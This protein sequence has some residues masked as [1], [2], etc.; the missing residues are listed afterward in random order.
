MA[1]REK[2]DLHVDV[3][4]GVF[5][6]LRPDQF[7]GVAT[8]ERAKEA[9]SVVL[10]E[11]SFPSLNI[12]FAASGRMRQKDNDSA[13]IDSKL[14]QMEVRL[15]ISPINDQGA[16][17]AD[18]NQCVVLGIHPY[19]TKTEEQ[20]PQLQIT[21]DVS[22]LLTAIPGIPA[23][24]TGV[25]SALGLTFGPLFKPK[26]PIIENAFF[27]NRREFGWYLRS[28]KENR[29]EGIHY[30]LAFLQV[31]RKVSKL[32]VDVN[33]GSD[34]DGGGVDVQS[35]K[36]SITIE[37]KHP[38]IPDTPTI[39][40]FTNP[41]ELPLVI[42]RDDVKTLLSIDDADLDQL[43][44]SSNGLVAFGKDRKHITKGSLI[45]VLELKTERNG[46]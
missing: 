11:F 30:G 1:G 17:I 15:I 8:A 19:E 31:S 46:N 27:G 34:W 35:E 36:P 37:V 10:Q 6:L 23:A 7:T 29:K 33:F 38:K 41:D 44:A 3:N 14:K 16:V 5:G 45:R 32:K 24:V 43:L 40:D 18:P 39:V 26:F 28:S 2:V 21:P 22:S 4:L 20:D 9:V 42:P 12:V 13:V 25:V